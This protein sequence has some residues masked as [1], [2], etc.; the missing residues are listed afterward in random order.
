M[1][2]GLNV[3]AD[4]YGQPMT[5]LYWNSGTRSGGIADALKALSVDELRGFLES[6]ERRGVL[7]H[8]RGEVAKELD[9]RKVCE[10]CRGSLCLVCAAT[11]SGVSTP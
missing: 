2:P 9:R 3:V 4:R 6:W 10:W 5:V 8:E 11:T 7:Y 1:T